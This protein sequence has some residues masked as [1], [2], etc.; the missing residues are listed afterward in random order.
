MNVAAQRGWATRQLDFS[1]SFVRATREEEFY[2]EMPAM[3][4]DKNANS[5]E[6]VVLN[7]S[8]S[9]YGLVHAPCTCYQHL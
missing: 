4:S 3:L 1:D 7:L 6:T 8:K 5:E 2:V 9:L